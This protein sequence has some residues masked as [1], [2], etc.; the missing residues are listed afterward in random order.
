MLTSSLVQAFSASALLLCWVESLSLNQCLFFSLWHTYTLSVFFIFIMGSPS[1]WLGKLEFRK[2]ERVNFF[3][4]ELQWELQQLRVT[5]ALLDSWWIST[6]GS[7]LSHSSR[8]ARGQSD[9]PESS[10]PMERNWTSSWQINL[11]SCLL[12]QGKVLRCIGFVKPE[13]R[14]V[15]MSERLA[16]FL[17]TSVVR[18]ILKTCIFLFSLS[19]FPF[20]LALAPQGS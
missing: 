17:P 12:C 3:S 7:V 9:V 20:P 4:L 5:G 10:Y 13:W 14:C 1:I 16:I 6:R 8:G 11:A 15:M 18:S 2:R 19:V